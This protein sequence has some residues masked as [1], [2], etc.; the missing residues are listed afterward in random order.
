[1]RRLGWG[2]AL[3]GGHRGQALPDGAAGAC[4]RRQGWVP[5]REELRVAGGGM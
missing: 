4:G 1:M 5:A 3:L 2:S